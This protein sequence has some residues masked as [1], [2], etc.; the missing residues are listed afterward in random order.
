MRH[1]RRYTR[2]AGSTTTRVLGNEYTWVGA[3]FVVLV[4]IAYLVLQAAMTSHF[5]RLE[6][7]NISG[8]AARV[9]TSLGYET[10]LISNFVLTNAEWDD[11]YD[12]IVDRD[13][14]AAAQAFIPAQMRGSFG[15]GALTLLDH[16]GAVVGGGMISPSDAYRPVSRS[17]ASGL[18]RLAGQTSCGVLA[19]VE[20]HYLYCAAPVVHTDGS[21][22]PAGTL[23]ALRTLD[24]A[25]AAAIGRRAGLTMQVA[26]TPLRGAATSLHSALGPLMVQTRDASGHTIDLI[27]AVPAVQGGAPLVL[28]IAF[29][30]PV[31]EA[32]IQSA[33]TSAEI[34]SVLGV[35]LLAISILAQ[36][37]GHAR[38]NRIFQRAVRD[39]AAVG[40]RVAPPARDLAVLA[41]SVNELLE[42]MNA[43]Q[44]EAQRA[45]E[46]AAAERAAAAA[47]THES[48]ARA[49]RE[50]QEA[51]AVAQREREQVTA[52]AAQE[53]DRAAALA[54]HER[55]EAA[56]QARRASAADARVALSEIDSTL[57][58]FVGAADTIE[59]AAQ[60]TLQAAAAARARVEEA[61]EGSL[62]LRET[63]SAAAEVTREISAVAAQTR[64]LALNAAIEAARAGEHGRGFAVVAHEVG[65]L[66]NAAATAAARVLEHIRNVSTGSAGVAASIEQTSAT[67]AAVDQATRR[68]DETVVAQ[69]AATRASEATLAAA[70]ERLVQIAE[71]RTSTRVSAELPVRL[72]PVDG[73][74]APVE[75]VT[76]DLSSGGALLRRCPGLG[77]GPWRL[78]LTLAGDPVPLRCV[79]SLARQ[80]P[81]HCGVAFEGIGEADLRRLHGVLAD[82][83]LRVGAA[84]VADRDAA[85]DPVYA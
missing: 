14:A 20:A 50:R 9:S 52:A 66:A 17:L 78:E 26:S 48:E 10:S 25:G 6:R 29:D 62:T 21:G 61:V 44:L 12:A 4:A 57:E 31:H 80:T 32:A 15:F 38:R 55:D 65:E 70:A 75:T 64:L 28:E 59:G 24:G 35:A 7:E 85:L 76:A 63:T 77:E 45:R 84:P 30:R 34:I 39:A 33:A 18:S 41:T 49:L 19:A 2:S 54:Q 81:N 56:S 42:V 16:A 83:E 3:A 58:V 22:P 74:G 1:L 40:G 23:V 82:P 13:P 72:T 71:R 5:D 46:A 43:R 37:I 79:A 73:Q 36:R 47:A 51:A 11:A 8:Q 60:E 69:R 67:L 68:I 53:R 27:L